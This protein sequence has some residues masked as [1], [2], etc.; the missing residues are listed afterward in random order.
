MIYFSSI[1]YRYSSI[2]IVKEN[3]S[4]I[5]VF[6][7]NN[8]FSR[9]YKENVIKRDDLKLQDEVSQIIE[10]LNGKR[11]K[12]NIRYKFSGTEFQKL[13]WQKILDTGYAEVKRYSDIAKEINKPLATRAV[14]NACRKNALPIIIPC[15]RVVS[16]NDLGGFFGQDTEFR[17]IK[18]YLINLERAYLHRPF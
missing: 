18:S 3:E 7:N 1:S 15:H 16:A 9:F 5:K 8:S 11:K 4:V 10:Y 2:Y 17:E 6:L 14:G 13:V 12:F